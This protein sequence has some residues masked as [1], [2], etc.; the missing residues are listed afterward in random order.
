[1]RLSRELVNLNQYLIIRICPLKQCIMKTTMVM[2][3]KTVYHEDDDDDDD[4]NSV[5]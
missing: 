2:M 1:M 4:E 3:M 5:S